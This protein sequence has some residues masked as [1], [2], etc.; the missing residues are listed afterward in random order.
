ML[1]NSITH[2][3]SKTIYNRLGMLETDTEPS[4]SDPFVMPYVIYEYNHHHYGPKTIVSPFLTSFG[5]HENWYA[6]Y[7]VNTF[8]H[9]HA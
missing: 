4:E 9:T 6:S 8:T 5:Q 1:Q 2:L 3:S 7:S